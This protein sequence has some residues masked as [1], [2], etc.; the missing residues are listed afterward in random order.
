MI[1]ATRKE[2]PIEPAPMIATARFGKLPAVRIRIKK[3]S[4]GRVGNNQI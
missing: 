1:K 4:N 2:S 3:P